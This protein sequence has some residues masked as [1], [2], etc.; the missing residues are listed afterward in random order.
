MNLTAKEPYGLWFLNASCSLFLL[1]NSCLGKIF[2]LLTEV[3]TMY[4]VS[5]TSSINT[6]F[7]KM[8][9]YMSPAPN[10]QAG[11]S[12]LILL[13]CHKLFNEAISAN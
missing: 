8:M 7:F 5:L 3:R 2:N 12:P 9:S 13:L 11:G 4:T 1:T 6:S 10:L